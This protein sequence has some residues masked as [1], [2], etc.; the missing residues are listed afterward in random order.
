MFVII[1]IVIVFVVLINR[2]ICYPYVAQG[3]V[4][5]AYIHIP[6]RT[7]PRPDPVEKR[8]SYTDDNGNNF[9]LVTYDIAE[10][11]ANGSYIAFYKNGKSQGSAFTN[12]VRSRYFPAISLYMGAS[13][14]CNFGPNFKYAPS[15]TCEPISHLSNTPSQSSSKVS[16]SNAKPRSTVTS[17][18]FVN[19]AKE[20]LKEA[21]KRGH[22]PKKNRVEQV[23][24]LKSNAKVPSR[25]AAPKKQDVPSKD[26]PMDQVNQTIIKKKRSTDRP[27]TDELS[28][29]R[30]KLK[31]ETLPKI[32]KSKKSNAVSEHQL[33][34]TD[35]PMV[36]EV[37]KSV[38][39][40]VVQRKNETNQPVN[41]QPI[42]Q[43]KVIKNAG[44]SGDI[45]SGIV[46]SD[47]DIKSKV[48]KVSQSDKVNTAKYAKEPTKARVPTKSHAPPVKKAIQQLNLRAAP[49]REVKVLEEIPEQPQV[50]PETQTVIP[51]SSVVES[52]DDTTVSTAPTTHFD[53]QLNVQNSQVNIRANTTRPP[54][55]V[56][57]AATKTESLPPSKD[58]PQHS[59]K[60]SWEAA[61]SN[62]LQPVPQQVQ[63]YSEP[64][65]S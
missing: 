37:T 62:I 7:E 59:A 15:T 51:T 14:T 63:L 46:E 9:C 65:H 48:E 30:K 2:M 34:P 20:S 42:V 13:V 32:P 54:Q 23:Q 5:G 26:V 6:E 57:D 61:A 36:G 4:I 19:A 64:T 60:P 35:Q 33:V 49:T 38:I 28:P 27:L 56:E 11:I 58:K 17:K 53:G 44:G 45:V 55:I 39:P 41:N 1:I 16:S 21:V 25:K 47:K 29:P 8:E 12:L 43:E 18:T 22:T 24:N 10:E 50:K 52:V 3:D 40:D 31:K